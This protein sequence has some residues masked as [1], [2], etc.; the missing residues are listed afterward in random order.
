MKKGVIVVFVL[1]FFL[2]IVGGFV[3]GDVCKTRLVSKGN[4]NWGPEEYCDGAGG[5]CCGNFGIISSEKKTY[6]QDGY[7]RTYNDLEY[8][9][10]CIP[11]N[12]EQRCVI[13][14]MLVD[15][16]VNPTCP[17]GERGIYSEVVRDGETYVSEVICEGSD[18]MGSIV[19]SI[20]RNPEGDIV[21]RERDFCPE[22]VPYSIPSY[23]EVSAKR[24]ELYYKNGYPRLDVDG[25]TYS[26]KLDSSYGYSGEYPCEDYLYGG[27]SEGYESC[28]G[29]YNNEVVTFTLKN[30][31]KRVCSEYS[32]NR[33]GDCFGPGETS[34]GSEK[35]CNSWGLV[36][37]KSDVV[38]GTPTDY[39]VCEP[40]GIYPIC[41]DSDGNGIASDCAGNDVGDSDSGYYDVIEDD[42]IDAPVVPDELDEPVT[43]SEESVCGDD[44]V[45]EGEECDD[46]NVVPGDG[47]DEN[48]MVEEERG[49][50]M[51][52]LVSMF[53]PAE[54]MGPFIMRDSSVTEKGY[55]LVA[56]LGCVEV[57]PISC[58]S[59]FSSSAS[60]TGQ[61]VGGVA[62]ED[63]LRKASPNDFEVVGVEKV[64]E[65]S[66]I[67]LDNTG[68]QQDRPAGQPVIRV[69][70]RKGS[71]E[72]KQKVYVSPVSGHTGVYVL[73]E[74]GEYKKIENKEIGDKILKEFAKKNRKGFQRKDKTPSMVT[75]G[76]RGIDIDKKRA[77]ETAE[78]LSEKEDLGDFVS[79]NVKDGSVEELAEAI[80]AVAIVNE[81]VV[82]HLGHSDAVSPEY[83][84]KWKEAIK[85]AQDKLDDRGF[86]IDIQPVQ[87]FLE[88]LTLSGVEG[89]SQKDYVSSD[90]DT[91]IIYVVE[92]E[93][94]EE[95]RRYIED[96]PNK[97]G[98]DK[99]KDALDDAIIV[100]DH[101]LWTSDSG[102][103]RVVND[104]SS[105]LRD[106]LNRRGSRVV[107]EDDW[108]PDTDEGG[109]SGGGND[110]GESKGN[111]DLDVLTEEQKK[112][113]W[114]GV[115]QT[116]AVFKGSPTEEEL[117]ARKKELEEGRKIA[118]ERLNDAGVIADEPVT[119]SEDELSLLG[120]LVEVVEDLRKS[121]ER[122]L[123]RISQLEANQEA[124]K[125]ARKENAV[126]VF[127]EKINDRV[128]NELPTGSEI[129]VGVSCI[130]EPA[131]RYFIIEDP[132]FDGESDPKLY[133]A[134]EDPEPDFGCETEED[135]ESGE[136]CIEGVCVAD[137]NTGEGGDNSMGVECE[138]S[139]D[140]TG[141]ELCIGGGCMTINEFLDS[142]KEDFKNRGKQIIGG[143]KKKQKQYI[144]WDDF[145]TTPLENLPDE[146]KVPTETDIPGE[147]NTLGEEPTADPISPRGPDSE[148]YIP[149]EGDG[150]ADLS[151]Q[152]ETDVEEVLEAVKEDI[153]AH[154][155]DTNGDGK[156]DTWE[157]TS[158]NE[159]HGFFEEEEEKTD[160]WGDPI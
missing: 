1:V 158:Y 31:D 150:E 136:S 91:E 47:C 128:S 119:L 148:P 160:A 69:T 62:S 103:E 78:G 53:S 124:I 122:E 117:E 77:E 120:G 32:R 57:T 145:E 45:D 52:A 156:V 153:D 65:S 93:H 83:S 85:L 66:P 113:I 132:S 133:E 142:G 130:P 22:S 19:E 97:P 55:Y 109:S 87:I 99:M 17:R 82:L 64:L 115:E 159:K 108:A 37:N 16:G 44:N 29:E 104:I 107:E 137:V 25:R 28:M 86:D 6:M 135:C 152:S 147:E 149:V 33:R 110:G 60:I 40:A 154:P 68:D 92:E 27:D 39:S 90:D 51:C 5:S 157:A 155:A 121:L 54:P 67:D 63:S 94:R 79:G 46:G 126:D 114:K 74:D 95:I 98:V 116:R 96:N 105:K 56:D 70:I 100:N 138:T 10:L 38:C 80:V 12:S 26:V 123:D 7:R 73:E 21:S 30:S 102:K 20:Q 101:W 18:G 23:F 50:E 11:P 143:K 131:E 43:P 59:Y 49:G 144:E 106:I 14:K 13:S 35:T 127:S 141:E 134:G 75:R 36:Y 4:Y 24:G 48:C 41:I 71:K 9:T 34:L 118:E 3:S 84:K 151:P 111:E 139:N 89:E 42:S 125:K 2:F 15:K 140:C 8:E 72:S 76:L 61:A 81:G 146:Q 112:N 58:P 129:S 88:P